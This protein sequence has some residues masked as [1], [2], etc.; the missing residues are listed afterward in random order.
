MSSILSIRVPDQVKKVLGNLASA[1]GRSKTWLAQEALER[2][3]KEESW[4]V[5][6]IKT[7]LKEADAGDFAMDN[8]VKK[9]FK[10][11]GANAH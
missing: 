3:L 6:E 1:T 11:W 4:Q 5:Q 7:A 9:V 2:Y 8:A 10:K